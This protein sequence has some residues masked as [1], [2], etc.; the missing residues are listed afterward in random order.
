MKTLVA[1][2]SASGTTEKAARY[3]AEQLKCDIYEIEPVVLYTADDL[4]W[5]SQNSR[6]NREMMM[7]STRPAIDGHVD[8]M[9]EYQRIILGFPIWWS[10]APHIINSFLESYDMNGKQIV[11]FATSSGSDLK[12][13][14]GD[15]MRSAIGSRII[16]GKV[17][18]QISADECD[19]FINKL[20]TERE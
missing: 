2:F 16:T 14:A 4:N 11:L 6:A 10:T 13:V 19:R 5:T 18:N 17:I 1:Y 3:I 12:K 8:N 7:P 15:L 20:K 9:D